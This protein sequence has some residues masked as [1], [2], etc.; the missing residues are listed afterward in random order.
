M[1]DRRSSPQA[2]DT[3]GK[4]YPT[5]RPVVRGTQ[6]IVSAGH[7]LTSMA[8]MR[9]LLD[10]GNAFDAVVA[11]GFAAT[12]LE[13]TASYSL[14]TEGTFMLYHAATG[15]LR[16]LSGQGVAPGRATVDFFKQRGSGQDSH[17]SRSKCGV[18]LHGARRRGRLHPD[19]GDLR[20]QDPR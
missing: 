2:G 14:A 17:R 20:D 5:G 13:P 10:G 4:K 1:V 15:E 9:M 8:G 18:G 12:V 6:G 3:G 11:A 19:A 16:V 7:Y